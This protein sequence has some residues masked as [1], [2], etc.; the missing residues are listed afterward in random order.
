MRGQATAEHT[1][2][3]V[4]SITQQLGVAC[5]TGNTPKGIRNGGRLLTER[6][7]LLVRRGAPLQGAAEHR[8][9]HCYAG[10]DVTKHFCC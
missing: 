9:E 8:P 2:A 1:A 4:A 3:D 5:M 7:K 10:S 6:R